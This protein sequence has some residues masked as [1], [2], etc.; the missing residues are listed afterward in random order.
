MQK[1]KLEQLNRERLNKLYPKMRRK[2]RSLR[3]IGEYNWKHLSL[4]DLLH[5]AFLRFIERNPLDECDIDD[6]HFENLLNWFIW[7]RARY[8]YNPNRASTIHRNRIVTEAKLGVEEPVLE[9]LTTHPNV[10]AD[11][12]V[13]LVEKHNYR[14][15]PYVL[16]EYRGVEIGE[17]LGV[18][19]TRANVLKKREIKH[20]LDT[21]PE[22]NQE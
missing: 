18:S 22:Y 8:S 15:L 2:Y 6:D 12:I 5:D 20:F 13:S 11:E 19:T 9:R 16:K 10:V 21:Y 14:V 4:E 17:I 1:Q 3:N 7:D